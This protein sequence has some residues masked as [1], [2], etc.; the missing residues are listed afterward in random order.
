MVVT[1]EEVVVADTATVMVDAEA[2]AIMEEDGWFYLV[3]LLK[4]L[5]KC[6]DSD[7]LCV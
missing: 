4:P 6:R 5:S 1:A 2:E 7:A 3:I